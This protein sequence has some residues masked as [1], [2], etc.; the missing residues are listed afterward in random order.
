MVG[1]R[2][3]G[4]VSEVA[5]TGVGAE[6]VVGACGKVSEEVEGE[7]RKDAPTSPP[8]RT[9]CSSV[10]TS[11]WTSP[12]PM[13]SPC[14]ARGLTVCAA[15]PTKTVLKSLPSLGSPRYVSA[16]ESRSGNDAIE[17][18]W[19]FS[20]SGGRGSGIALMSKV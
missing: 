20:T 3:D 4:V 15:S 11:D 13:L 8:S 6:G 2:E 1:G 17:P 5:G 12:S 16:C 14:P 10:A 19:T 9:V 7:E 18:S